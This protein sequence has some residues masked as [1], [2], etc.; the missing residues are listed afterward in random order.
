M[1][2][3]SAQCSKGIGSI[4]IDEKDHYDEL[5]KGWWR[6]RN[7]PVEEFRSSAV[8]QIR[9]AKHS[10]NRRILWATSLVP[11]L[12]SQAEC[13]DNRERETS[14]RGMIWEKPGR[15]VNKKASRQHSERGRDEPE[16]KRDHEAMP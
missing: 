5:Q 11:S 15:F 3:L 7:V 12:W 16:R 9:C 10:E 14:W 4:S 6:D 13:T 1:G 2:T 8:Q